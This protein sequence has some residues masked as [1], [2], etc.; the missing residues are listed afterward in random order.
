[1]GTLV[2]ANNLVD[3]DPLL[4]AQTSLAARITYVSTSGINDTHPHVTATVFVPV[5]L[6]TRSWTR[7]PR[8][9]T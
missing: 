8:A 4:R 5:R 9:T 6:I 3:L 7:R 2:A 1:M